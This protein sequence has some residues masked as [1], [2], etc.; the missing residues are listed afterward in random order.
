MTETYAL[1]NST[2]WFRNSCYLNVEI[3]QLVRSEHLAAEEDR[4]AETSTN[5][6]IDSQLMPVPLKKKKRKGREECEMLEKVLLAWNGL[7]I[8]VQTLNKLD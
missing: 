8:Q 2:M 6:I 7:A 1:I 5:H 4:D 3:F